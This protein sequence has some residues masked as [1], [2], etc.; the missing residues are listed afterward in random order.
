MHQL[1][2][3]IDQRRVGKSHRIDFADPQDRL[4]ALVRHRSV[5]RPLELVAD[6]VHPNRADAGQ[7]LEIDRQHAIIA[8]GKLLA[9]VAR[10]TFGKLVS[11]EERFA[12]H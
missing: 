3:H 7:A 2:I 12:G 4:S 11:G 5:G 1:G 6:V 10:N 8:A 9:H